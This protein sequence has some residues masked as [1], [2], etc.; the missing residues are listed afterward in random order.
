MKLSPKTYAQTLIESTNPDN[1]KSVASN[2]WRVLQKNKQYKD[3]T[4]IV[5]S[6]NIED[7]KKQDK[8]LVD[9]YSENE[10]N[11]NEILE[12]T[13]TLEKK[14]K[15]SIILQKNIKKNLHGGVLIKTEDEVFDLSINNKIEQLK[16][17]IIQ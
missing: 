9:I 5:E 11:I 7:A 12:I 17:I 8:I 16:R 1:I 15:K 14:F 2:F 10:L 4:K 13:N 6:L 3:F